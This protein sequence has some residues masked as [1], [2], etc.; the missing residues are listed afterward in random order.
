MARTVTGTIK[1][2][3]GNAAWAGVGVRFTL[4]DAFFVTTLATYPKNSLTVTTGEDGAFS[5]TLATPDSGT[6]RYR[7][8]LPNGESFEFDV[9]TGSAT[10]LEVIIAAGTFPPATAPMV[11]LRETGATVGATVAAQDFGTHGIKA[12]VIAESSSGAGVTIDGVLVKDALVARQGV[13]WGKN[14]LVVDAKGKGS[15]PT[16]SAALAAISD[17]TLANPYTVVVVG[18]VDETATVTAKSYVNVHGLAG[19]HLKVTNAAPAPAVSFSGVVFATW[20]DLKISNLGA[21]AA[22]GISLDGTD[23]TIELKDIDAETA[24]AYDAVKLVSGAVTTDNVKGAKT[25]TSAVGNEPG[26]H[27]NWI[28][29]GYRNVIEGGG[30]TYAAVIA[31]GYENQVNPGPGAVIVGG[32]QNK[33]SAAHAGI[34]GGSNNEATGDGSVILGGQT[35]K[36]TMPGEVAQSNG[37]FVTNEKADAQA[38]SVV[39][40]IATT[41]ATPNALSFLGYGQPGLPVPTNTVWNFAIRVAVMNQGATKA[42]GWVLEGVVRNASGVVTLVSTRTRTSWKTDEGLDC[43]VAANDATNCLDVTV[44]GLAATNLRW[45]GFVRLVQV[46]YP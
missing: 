21:N 22:I 42:G 43:D 4:V 35:A 20:A 18:T 31:G 44:V 33:V 8:D 5:V 36:T 26:G 28:G 25:T 10:T 38:M 24:G 6:I 39:Q 45:V 1:K 37:W 15:Y 27:F 46:Q 3:G 40:R 14:T 30:Q 19:A 12:D 16:L 2:P 11:Y 7:C 13:P 32:I 23:D 9:A 41:D 34:L 17:A 29:G